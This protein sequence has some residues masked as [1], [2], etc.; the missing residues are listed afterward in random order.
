MELAQGGK[1][2]RSHPGR[3]VR[4]SGRVRARIKESLAVGLVVGLAAALGGCGSSAG[5]TKSSQVRAAEIKG[6]GK[7]LVDG[8][9]RTLYIYMPDHQSAS[10]CSAV[11]AEQWPPLVLA[12]GASR[13]VA[14]PGVKASLLGTVK[15]S[16][17]QLQV[18]YNRW[19]LYLYI[20]DDADGQAN[21]QGDGMGAWYVMS[22]NGSVDRRPVAG[23]PRS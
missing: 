16:D 22:V 17:G 23:S 1:L 15:R 10:K 5:A 6:L 14:G 9:G 12:K 21:G 18:T 13:P 11:C 7:V 4:D 20:D 2:S 3:A 19:P 8:A